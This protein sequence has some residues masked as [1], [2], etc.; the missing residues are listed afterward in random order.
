MA[1][2][3][4]S[5]VMAKKSGMKVIVAGCRD[6]HD[7][8]FV[9]KAIEDSGFEIAELVSGGA[10]GVD[11]LGEKWARE[12]DVP[13]KVFAADW[14]RFGRCAGPMRNGKMAGYASA[15]VAV[16]DGTSPGTKSMIHLAEQWCLKVHVSIVRKPLQ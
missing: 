7:Y 6:F 5:A 16:W 1:A 11:A 2:A 3:S 14:S 9:V 4:A 13:V 8:D 15:L 12:N 10:K